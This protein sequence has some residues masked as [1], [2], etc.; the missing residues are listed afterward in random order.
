[1]PRGVKPFCCILRTMSRLKNFRDVLAMYRK[2]GWRLARV[3]ATVEDIKELRGPTDDATRDE[4]GE[5]AR[6]DSGALMFE[7]VLV[8]ES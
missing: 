7:G 2:H 4:S 1:M 5:E 3:L 6:D 8:V